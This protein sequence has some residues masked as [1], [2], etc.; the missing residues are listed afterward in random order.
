MYFR[1]GGSYWESSDASGAAD[2]PRSARLSDAP[3]G[4]RLDRPR[5]PQQPAIE[6]RGVRINAISEATCVEHI[7]SELD[8]GRGGMVVTPNLDHLHRSLHDVGFAALLSEADLVVAD[9]MP[10]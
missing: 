4:R 5:A 3:D 2:D 6:L 8:A 1:Y 9:G 7:L 10:L